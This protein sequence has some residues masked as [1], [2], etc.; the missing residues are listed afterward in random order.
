MAWDDVNK[1]LAL[2]GFYC[3]NKG[4]QPSYVPFLSVND[5]VCDYDLCCDG[6]DEWAQVGGLSCDDKCKDIGNQWK[7]QD[8]QRQKSIG[9]AGKKRKE[10][11]LEAL[12]LRK[13]VEDQIE[14]LKTKIAAS[15]IKVRETE[16]KVKEIERQEQGKVVKSAGKGNKMTILVGLAKERIEELREFLVDVK[17]QRDQGR[18]RIKELEAILTTFKE[19][20]N[21]NFNDEGVKR[22]VRSW[23][24]YAARDTPDDTDDA[25]ERDLAE[26]SRADSE[27]G[28][29]RWE[30]WTEA[31]ESDVELRKSAAPP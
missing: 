5:G 12:R 3:K 19:E 15:E 10:L 30:E 22:A 24:E 7:K 9:N 1:T 17:S 6:S 11:V 21:P 26:V 14:N 4:H 29:I 8:E 16:D 25:H 28:S 2:P 31:E 18:S 20:Y 27:S 13:E 23:E